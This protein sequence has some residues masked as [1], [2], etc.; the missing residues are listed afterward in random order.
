MPL[1]MRAESGGV[2]VDVSAKIRTMYGQTECTQADRFLTWLQ[3]A[4]RILHVITAGSY[5]I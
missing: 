3:L 1:R 2:V 4:C 5:G